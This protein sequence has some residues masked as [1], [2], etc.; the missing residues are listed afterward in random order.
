LIG[1]RGWPGGM[2]VY[3]KQGCCGAAAVV[4]EYC[5]AGVS[6]AKKCNGNCTSDPN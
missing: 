6:C 3:E 1:R 2:A 5:F 4:K